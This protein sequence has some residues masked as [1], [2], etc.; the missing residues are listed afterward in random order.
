MALTGMVGRWVG[1][2]IDGLIC[3]LMNCDGGL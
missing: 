3:E 2:W 1:G